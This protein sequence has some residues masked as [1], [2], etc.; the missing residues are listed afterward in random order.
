MTYRSWLA[1]ADD[2]HTDAE[3]AELIAEDHRA[4]FA[5][6]ERQI[7]KPR[8]PSTYDEVSRWIDYDYDHDEE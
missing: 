7:P 5:R 1:E 2:Y 4:W 3:S 6:R 8:E